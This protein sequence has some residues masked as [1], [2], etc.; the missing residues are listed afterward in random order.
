MRLDAKNAMGHLY[1]HSLVNSTVILSS[2]SSSIISVLITESQC[3]SDTTDA[4]NVLVLF[5]IHTVYK[6]IIIFLFTSSI[7]VSVSTV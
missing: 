1:K 6:G 4:K 3:T 7:Y 2:S 5:K